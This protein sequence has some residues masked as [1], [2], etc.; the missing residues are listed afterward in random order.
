MWHRTSVSENTPGRS[1][2]AALPTRRPHPLVFLHVNKTGGTSLS[3]FL[4]S[5]YPVDAC[6]SEQSDPSGW[7]DAGSDPWLDRV[8]AFDL[9]S[10]H[11]FDQR[12]LEALRDR[13]PTYRAVTLLRDP[14]QRTFSQ[15][16]AWR[17][18]SNEA[19]ARMG[20]VKRERSLDARRMPIAD[21]IDK[22]HVRLHNRQARMISGLGLGPIDVSD[23]A[24]ATA[25]MAALD[26][27]D[28]VGI[29]SRL[30]DFAPLLVWHMAFPGAHVDVAW[31][32]TPA[33]AVVTEEER[34]VVAVA[35]RDLNRADEITY[36]CAERRFFELRADTHFAQ[37]Q[38]VGA[39][40]PTARWSL[41]RRGTW[42]FGDP[43]V[44]VGWYDREGGIHGPSRWAGPDRFAALYL[45]VTSDAPLRVRMLITSVIDPSMLE[46]LTLH[47]NGVAVPF[48][49]ESVGGAS[50]LAFTVRPPAVRV[51]ALKL[52]LEFPAALSAR[53][54]AGL[55]DPRRKTVAIEQVD[56]EVRSDLPD[57]SVRY[58]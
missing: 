8:A 45:P 27:I 36:R 33:D 10:H 20:P 13:R 30:R 24:L 41:G 19:V 42:T 15:I 53:E 4:E 7:G 28:Y 56:V 34:S 52:M 54:V 26:T 16:A 50:W 25:A 43:L 1:A 31:N 44:A 49:L 46:S 21:F 14:V 22:H 37:A 32:A 40:P 17:R 29:T 47:A 35:V 58:P 18:T 9:I 3:R 6:L 38:V 55:A 11:H 39:V 57:G 2:G 12:V 51:A 23:D 48:Q 5:Q